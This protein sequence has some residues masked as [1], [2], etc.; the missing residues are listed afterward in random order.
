MLD[1]F[2]RPATLGGFGD[3]KP[4]PF[5]SR[6]RAMIYAFGQIAEEEDA[7]LAGARV[8]RRGVA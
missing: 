5:P 7:K 1:D 6:V 8:S 3:P 2:Y 4:P